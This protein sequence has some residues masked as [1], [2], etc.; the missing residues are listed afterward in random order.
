MPKLP[1]KTK[2]S[3]AVAA[4]S[5]RLARLQN[6]EVEYMIILT[7]FSNGAKPASG[8]RVLTALEH[9]GYAIDTEMAATFAGLVKDGTLVHCGVEKKT[10]F[11]LWK[12]APAVRNALVKNRAK[13]EAYLARRVLVPR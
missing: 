9:L 12:L 7:F 11:H 4:A 8:E 5:A 1:K 6:A 13:V 2:A 3:A 10:D